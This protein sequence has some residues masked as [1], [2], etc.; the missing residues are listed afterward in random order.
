MLGSNTKKKWLRSFSFPSFSTSS[1][2][3]SLGRAIGVGESVLVTSSA[4]C[5]KGR[6]LFPA[7]LTANSMLRFVSPRHFRV[8]DDEYHCRCEYRPRL[9]SFDLFFVVVF[10]YHNIDVSSVHNIFTLVM[11]NNIVDESTDHV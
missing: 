5:K 9:T 1:Y 6:A 11:T 10:F 8:S 3:I 4:W 2:Y 7:L